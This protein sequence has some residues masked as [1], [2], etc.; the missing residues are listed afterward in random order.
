MINYVG[1]KEKFGC[2][3]ACVAMILDKS[4]EETKALLPADRNYG[5]KNGLTSHDY[6]SFLF[7]HGFVGLTV[8]SC[9]SHTQ[10]K[11]EKSEW[12]KPLAEMNIVS[13]ITENG[14]HAVLWE[15]GRVHDPNIIGIFAIED[16][17]VQAITG[18]WDLK[19]FN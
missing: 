9:E 12:I 8:Y 19:K 4:Y 17:D 15:N 10:R 14:P 18:F 11:R 1:Q 7:H 3:I 2:A 5:N 13:V 16:F 6:I